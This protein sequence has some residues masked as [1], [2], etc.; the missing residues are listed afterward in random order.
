[1][2]LCIDCKHHKPV[3]LPTDAGEYDRCGHPDVMVIDLVRGQHSKPYAKITR[4]L[5]QKCGPAGDLFDY[6]PCEP[7]TN[8]GEE[9]FDVV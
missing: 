9:D 8:L 5:T 2:R 3:G 6:D 1:M 7:S 4:M